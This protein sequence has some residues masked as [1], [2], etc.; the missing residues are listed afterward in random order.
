MSS[1]FI[2]PAGDTQPALDPRAA[3][4]LIFGAPEE[5]PAEQPAAD[6][7]K[8]PPK[9]QYFGP[10]R[11]DKGR[12]QV[13]PPPTEVTDNA[14][15]EELAQE[16]D[17]APP[18]VE[19]PGETEEIDPAEELPTIDPPRSWTKE[20]KEA[21]QALPREH[22]QNIADRERARDADLRRRQDE[23]AAVRREA[24]AQ[25]HARIQAAEQARRHYEAALPQLQQAIQ[26]H[27][28]T[29]YQDIKTWVDVQKM[30]AEDPIRY[31]RW[32]A[33]QA[34][35]AQAKQA[36]KDAQDKADREAWD[37]FQGFKSQET[38]RFL[39]KAPEFADP[40]KAPKYQAQA[41]EYLINEIG[42]PEARLAAMYNGQASFSIHDHQFQ[43]IVR[44][45]L[46][47]REAKTAVTNKKPAPKPSSPPAQKP[48]VSVSQ[49]EVRSAQV[50]VLN[51][52][53][54]KTGSREAAFHLL[55]ATRS[56]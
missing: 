21:F 48:G 34:Q 41:R 45:A 43:L 13:A 2:G 30:A 18:E 29:E 12:F 56:R 49:G 36:A 31:S 50:D 5:T 22:Q 47:Y 51:K 42:V 10:K 7:P 6:A 44:D 3:A 38:Q 28:N 55:R 27:I 4:S 39:E 20:E 9:E 40:A 53:L 32:S 24:E 17:A 35:S 11:D 1:E 52:N 23:V 15:D 19:A 16:A 26:Q 8:Q 37:S 25:A 14:P 33:A 54:D 46:K